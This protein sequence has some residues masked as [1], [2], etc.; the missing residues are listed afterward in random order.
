MT[1]KYT[2]DSFF[3]FLNLPIK[4]KMT[5]QLTI[6]ISNGQCTLLLITFFDNL[7]KKKSN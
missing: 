3:L 5:I 2:F 6:K 7:P 4:H 1:M